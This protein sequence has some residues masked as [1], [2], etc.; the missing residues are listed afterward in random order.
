MFDKI[1]PRYDF[2]NRTLSLSRDV[3]WRREMVKALKLSSVKGA[4]I[5]D[6]ACGTCDVAMEAVRQYG[7]KNQ[8]C[9][10]DFSFSML[11]LGKE[12][13]ETNG[14]NS[15][16]SLISGNALGLPF[17]SG[18]FDA[19]TIAFGIRNIADKKKA[20]EEFRRCLKKG[21]IL[22]V[23]ELT[24]P[25]NKFLNALYM[26]YFTKILPFV[27]GFFS[28]NLSAYQYLPESVVRFPDSRTFGAIMESAGFQTV[29]WKK[30]TFGIV[31]LYTGISR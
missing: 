18:Q 2:L 1:A 10:A 17:P 31:T 19:V 23:L 16:I 14:L 27:G 20:L 4:K 12:K 9:G 25:E 8:I 11:L 28:K 15:V 21:G 7:E 6:V 24:T 29:T 5:L 26:A 22:A 30:M 13:I 3:V